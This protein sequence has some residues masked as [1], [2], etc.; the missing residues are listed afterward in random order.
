MAYILGRKKPTL[1]FPSVSGSVCNFNSQYAGLPL[2]SHTV[3]I[4]SVSGVSAINISATGKN[5][6]KYPYQTITNIW[7]GMSVVENNGVLTIEG[8]QN[9]V[10]SFVFGEVNLKKN[11][12][13]TLS[14][15]Y[16]YLSGNEL[17]MNLTLYDFN[18]NIVVKNVNLNGGSFTVNNDCTARLYLNPSSSANGKYF[19]FTVSP[20]IEVGNGT[21]YTLYNGSFYT[22]PIGQTVNEG[23]YDARTGILEATSPT[24]QTLQLPPCPIDT[25]EGV[26]NIWADTGDTTLQYPKFG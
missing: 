20:Q 23:V 3:N 25:L 14:P 8:T 9:G 18:N 13:Y 19:H 2:K 16:D 1:L 26:N 24:A 10:G 12:T 4:D 15:F 22:I 7:N 17:Y 11:I 21:S 6:V 5:L